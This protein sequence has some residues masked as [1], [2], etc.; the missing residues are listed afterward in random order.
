M[1]VRGSPAARRFGRHRGAVAGAAIALAFAAVALLAPW[2]APHDPEAVQ[3][4][5]NLR[6][7]SRVHPFGTDSLGRDVLSQTIYGARISLTIGFVS[8]ALAVLGGVPIGALA[9]YTGGWTDRLTMR[10]VDILVSFPT[11]LLAIVV[12]TIFG[13]GLFHAMIAIGI[14]Q[15]PLYARLTRGA[16][17]KVKALDYAA[18]ARAVGA[19]ALR[20]LWRHVLPNCLPPLIVQSTLFFATAILSAAYLGFLGLGAQPPTPEWGTMLSKARDFLRVAPHV[21]V[22]PGL[23]I[24]VTVLGLNLL[25]DGL[26]DVLDPRT[27]LTNSPQRSV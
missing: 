26:R 18:A 1:R 13:P 22:F 2:L 20:I 15:V 27:G 23:T 6:P 25:G 16:V 9:G 10:L 17:L 3:L 19:P 4:A 12:I 24:M 7:P 11:L 5:N 14:A 21:S 8:V